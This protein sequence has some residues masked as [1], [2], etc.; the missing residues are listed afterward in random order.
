MN[1]ELNTPEP[2]APA[3]PAI[4]FADLARR[5][6]SRTTDLIAIAIVVVASLTLGRQVLEWWH[7]APQQ[8]AAGGSA[9]AAIR[10][11]WEDKL[12]PVALEFG[13]IPLSMT[14][15][16]VLG[17]SKTVIA[18]L[19]RHCETTVR[20]TREPW[21]DVDEAEER[22]FARTAGL[23]PV[24]AERDAWQVY[25]IDE[26]FPMV[27]GFRR[28]PTGQKEAARGLPRLVCWG[29]AM[30]A[31]EGVWNLFVFQA[32]NQDGPAAPSGLSSIPIPPQGQKNLSLR[33]QQGGLLAGFSGQ[34][35]PQEWVKYYDGWF[36][37]RGWSSS[38]GWQ[39]AGAAWSARFQKPESPQSG[40]VEIQFV[41]HA[42]QELTGLLWVVP[43]AQNNRDAQK[44]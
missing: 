20:T 16:T 36:T 6:T 4:G 7:A 24:A 42:N 44:E 33:D 5:M 31:G 25:V 43:P 17:T 23:K 41:E 9:T 18:E 35:M 37:E 32:A 2:N 27:A 12:Q 10:P 15:Q 38:D 3:K 19:V 11:V 8:Q 21:R 13:D 1:P 28:F 14:R 34:G 29:M 40:R 39:T 22:L 26:H 30:S